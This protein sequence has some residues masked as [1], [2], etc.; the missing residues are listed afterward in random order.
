MKEKK[1]KNQKKQKTHYKSYPPNLASFTACGLWRYAVVN[2]R[3]KKVTAN[4]K[5]VDCGRCKNMRSFKEK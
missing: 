2:T 4:K 3:E 5:D 1:Q